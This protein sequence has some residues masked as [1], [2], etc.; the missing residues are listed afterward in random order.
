MFEKKIKDLLLKS[1]VQK[2]V[3]SNEKLIIE[4]KNQNIC[5]FQSCE[6]KFKINKRDHQNAMQDGGAVLSSRTA[7]HKNLPSHHDP[8]TFI[9]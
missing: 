4:E 8:N 2:N 7:Q 3:G 6:D 1:V 5:I 9:S